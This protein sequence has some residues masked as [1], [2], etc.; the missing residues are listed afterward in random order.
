[1]HCQILTEILLPKQSI[2]RKVESRKKFPTLSML[3]QTGHMLPL[4]YLME[5]PSWNQLS[6]NLRKKVSNLL[7][8]HF[9]QQKN[10]SNLPILLHLKVTFE[11]LLVQNSQRIEYQA[12]LPQKQEVLPAKPPWRME[13]KWMILQVVQVME[14]NRKTQLWPRLH[15]QPPLNHLPTLLLMT[16]ENF[17]RTWT[18]TTEHHMKFR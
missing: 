4:M 8:H 18:T 2:D 17:K 12:L 10:R 3:H 11:N 16:R 1:M 9:L 6:M 5:T 14:I 13:C 15:H 7:L